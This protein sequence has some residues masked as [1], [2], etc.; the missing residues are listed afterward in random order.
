MWLSSTNR[1]TK[2]KDMHINYFS[3]NARCSHLV[4]KTTK[5]SSQAQLPNKLK[6]LVS[7]M[8][9]EQAI[10]EETCCLDC[11]LYWM[12]SNIKQYMAHKSAHTIDYSFTQSKAYHITHKPHRMRERRARQ[13]KRQCKFIILYNINKLYLI[14]NIKIY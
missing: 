8:N 1:L 6:L 9:I 11:R 3:N 4:C 2:Q 5:T 7:Y 14:V 12:L 10:L 13:K